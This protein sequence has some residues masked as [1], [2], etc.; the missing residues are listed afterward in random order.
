MRP[1]KNDMLRELTS[2]E[3]STQI[4]NPFYNFIK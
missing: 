4:R 2:E 3:V 1:F